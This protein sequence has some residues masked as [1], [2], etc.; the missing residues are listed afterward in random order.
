MICRTFLW[1]RS[2]ERCMQS[3]TRVYVQK[4]IWNK[5]SRITVKF[6]LMTDSGWKTFLDQYTHIQSAAH[7]R[8]TSSTH[9]NTCNEVNVSSNS[10]RGSQSLNLCLYWCTLSVCSFVL[11]NAQMYIFERTL[12]HSLTCSQFEQSQREWI[13]A[14]CS[15]LLGRAQTRTLV[16]FFFHYFY[17]RL[18]TNTT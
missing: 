8:S 6:T 16:I 14:N 18:V 15:M 12:A 13:F 5:R 7:M 2:S 10:Q 4:N 3:A 11:C 17:V 1:N 9:C